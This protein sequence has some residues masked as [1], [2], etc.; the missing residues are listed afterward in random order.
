[1]HFRRVAE[2]TDRKIVIYNIPY[3]TG[4]NL[5]NDTL[6]RLA[7]LPNVVGVKDSCGILTQSLDL[8]RRRPAGLSVMTGE[9]AFYYTQLA[10]GGD[11]G[12][13][14]SAH[15]HTER[16]VA[17]WRRMADNDHQGARTLW[18]PLETL[19]PLLFQEA[20]PMPIK[21]GLWKQGL[22]KSPECRLPLTRISDALAA[23]LEARLAG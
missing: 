9:D 4:V 7:E 14:A 12:I 8:L 23:Q 21:Y 17:I 19:I 16:F 13:L 3:R 5:M 10:H 15:L 18:A 22:I 11:G 1:M 6:L 20:N 2:A